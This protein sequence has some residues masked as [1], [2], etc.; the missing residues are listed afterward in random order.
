M[1]CYK[2]I[3][4]RM[5]NYESIYGLNEVEL[6]RLYKEKGYAGL[7]KANEFAKEVFNYETK[8]FNKEVFNKL[9][10]YEKT[11]IRSLEMSLSGEYEKMVLANRSLMTGEK[12]NPYKSQIEFKQQTIERTANG[13]YLSEVLK[14]IFELEYELKQKYNEEGDK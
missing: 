1:R 3:D 7:P 9:T 10:L 4:E 12:Y 14:E 11:Y 6:D 13:E 5:P 2:M 8:Y